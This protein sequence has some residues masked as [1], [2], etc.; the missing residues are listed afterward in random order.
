MS[1]FLRKINAG[2]RR[3]VFIRDVVHNIKNKIAST[4]KNIF[5][6]LFAALSFT[7]CKTS[8]K[9]EVEYTRER[10]EIQHQNVRFPEPVG[11]VND[12]DGIFTPDQ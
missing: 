3:T 8:S 1:D 5:L 12:F 11:F 6:V 2:N 10:T 4:L 9:N 7:A